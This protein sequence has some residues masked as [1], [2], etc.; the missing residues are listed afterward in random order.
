MFH[1][2]WPLLMVVA[3][4][5]LYNISSKSLP[6]NC[7][8]YMTLVITYLIASFLSLLGYFIFDEG[9]NF[10]PDLQKTNWTGIAL[11][12]SM[13]GLEIGYIFMYRFGWKISVASLL[14]NVLLAVALLIIGMTFYREKL[15][16]R[17]L[18]G[19]VMCVAGCAVLL[20]AKGQ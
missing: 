15:D 3:A 12:I 16:F 11:G 7:S 14:A 9:K 19:I 8:P 17:Q 18:F 5:I 1:M 10:W 20:S 4:N 13:V 2:F 6:A